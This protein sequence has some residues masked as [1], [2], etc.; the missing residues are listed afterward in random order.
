MRLVSRPG[1]RAL[2]CIEWTV[3]GA[4]TQEAAEECSE[5]EAD[6]A[7]RVTGIIGII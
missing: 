7:A 5:A 4:C 3:A 2:T 1:K 6:I